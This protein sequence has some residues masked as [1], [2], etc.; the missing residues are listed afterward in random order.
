MR[1]WEQRSPRHYSPQ[2][3]GSGCRAHRSLLGF[4]P[5]GWARRLAWRGL[6]YNWHCGQHHYHP[7]HAAE[8]LCCA[9]GKCA[10]AWPLKV[11]N[12]INSPTG[13]LDHIYLIFNRMLYL[14][15]NLSV[16]LLQRGMI[17]ETNT[18]RYICKILQPCFVCI[19]FTCWIY[20]AF[21]TFQIKSKLLSFFFLHMELHIMGGMV[22]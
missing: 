19:P 2:T 1:P 18:H 3:S 20:K 17:Y 16:C 7:L 8:E 6:P 10:A 9:D 11:I 21:L 22:A 12:P 15:C 13:L 5:V 4:W 14:L